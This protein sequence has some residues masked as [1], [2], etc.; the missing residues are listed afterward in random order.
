MI[1]GRSLRLLIDGE[2]YSDIRWGVKLA[3]GNVGYENK[4]LMLPQWAAFFLPRLVR[5]FKWEMK[6]K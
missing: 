1:C 2:H 6:E 3:H 5:E 4:V